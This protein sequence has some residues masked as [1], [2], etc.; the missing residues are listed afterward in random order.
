MKDVTH[1]PA[2]IAGLAFLLA[3]VFGAIGQR[4]SF[5]TM[6]SIADIV[7]FGDWRRMRMWLLAIAVAIA[8]ATA[9]QAAGLI[10]LSKT[11][12]TGTKVSWLSLLVGGFLFGVG[13]TLGSGCGS[14][15]L[16]RL[17]AG[18]LKAVVVVVFLAISAYM[19]LRGVFA[20][21][22]VNGLDPVRFDLAPLGVTTSDLPSIVVTLG[23]GVAAK[24][25]LPLL[26]AVLLGAFV[27]ANRDFRATR[28]MIVGGIV[29]GA[30]IVGAG[31]SRAIW[32]IWPRI[33]RR[34]RKNS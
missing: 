26:I 7:V 12:Y 19:T 5:C 30:V 33:R 3:A 21:W 29:I 18:N 2:L 4:V 16:I 32:G 31:M 28:E 23:L 17:G 20:L 10:D 15:N 13:M 24:L 25:W 14:K 9:L 11:I 27:F 6:G 22:R 34:S 8:G 1:L